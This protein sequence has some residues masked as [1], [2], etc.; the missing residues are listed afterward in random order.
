[1]SQQSE[2]LENEQCIGCWNHKTEWK[3]LPVIPEWQMENL[4]PNSS[5]SQN[6]EQEMERLQVL[7]SYFILGAD[8]DPTFERLT[9]LAARIFDVPI[10]LVSLVDFGRQWFLSNRGLGETRET[11]RKFAFCAHAILSNHDVFVVPDASKDDRFKDN[12]LVVGDPYIRFYAGAPLLCPQ[13][14]K[15][16]TFC[17]IHTRP[18]PDGL[19][20][21]QKQ[22]L[23]EIAALV[24]DN[25]VTLKK[26]KESR[27]QESAQ[28]IACTAHDLL[29]PLTAINLNLS[30]LL[31][32]E[33][34]KLDHHQQDLIQTAVNCTDVMSRLCHQTMD[35]Y[36]G[37]LIK[38]M[39]RNDFENFDENALIADGEDKEGAVVIS[40]LVENISQVIE[41]YPK[42]SASNIGYS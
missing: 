12:P 21:D 34:L 4:D 37:S 9:A 35:S 15:L 31:E 18:F 36:R 24:M 11:P 1:M 3:K 38:D 7:K 14:Y 6:L 5:S 13:G 30:L 17:I 8:R 40:R 16:G 32:D 25:L 22:N 23:R 29:T 41:A 33:S 10:A 2:N 19:S 39:K 28:A 27:H 20:L 26:Q 42:K